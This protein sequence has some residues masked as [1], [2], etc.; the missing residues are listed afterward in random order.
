MLLVT[1]VIICLTYVVMAQWCLLEYI[2]SHGLFL[3]LVHFFSELTTFS[4]P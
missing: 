4:H 1:T 3:G 2:L